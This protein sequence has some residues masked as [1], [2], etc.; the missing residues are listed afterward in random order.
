MK[1][2]QHL[3]ETREVAQPDDEHRSEQR[4]QEA[5]GRAHLVYQVINQAVGR[6]AR[7]GE[8]TAGRQGEGYP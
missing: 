7:K 2:M 6:H 8:P 3:P 5:P 4:R 1:G